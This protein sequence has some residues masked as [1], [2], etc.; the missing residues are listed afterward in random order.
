MIYWGINVCGNC[1]A[2]LTTLSRL[3]AKKIFVG[4][5]ELI[6]RKLIHSILQVERRGRL[7]NHCSFLCALPRPLR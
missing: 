5:R 3:I 6:P 4:A 1:R 2:E 7:Q